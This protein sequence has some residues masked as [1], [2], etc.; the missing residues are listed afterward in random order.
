MQRVYSA[1]FVPPLLKITPLKK[2]I[3]IIIIKKQNKT[4]EDGHQE[5]KSFLT[6]QYTVA[7]VVQPERGGVGNVTVGRRALL[8]IK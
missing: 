4:K 7:T 1:N 8:Y 5:K 3:I 6:A 2:K